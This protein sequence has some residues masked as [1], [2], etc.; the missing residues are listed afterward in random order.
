MPTVVVAAV[1]V[2]PVV[3]AAVVV[4]EADFRQWADCCL[5]WY[6]PLLR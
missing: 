5:A 3:V 6:R 4:A 2:T 1:V